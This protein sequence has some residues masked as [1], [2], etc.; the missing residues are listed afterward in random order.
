MKH[1]TERESIIKL[2]EKTIIEGTLSQTKPAS[3][4]RTAYGL[5]HRNSIAEMQKLRA[6]VKL[7]LTMEDKR[8]CISSWC[9]GIP[10]RYITVD[11]LKAIDV[12]TEEGNMDNM[13]FLDLNLKPTSK[14]LRISA[15]RNHYIVQLCGL[16]RK[17]FTVSKIKTLIC[18]EGLKNFF[19]YCEEINTEVNHYRKTHLNPVGVYKLKTFIGCKCVGKPTDYNMISLGTVRA[20]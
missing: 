19:D 14:H 4:L 10:S 13:Y 9:C 5:D 15:G 16:L 2:M 12:G 8:A 17:G 11:T 1:L 7:K 18:N 3:A 20:Q 6:E